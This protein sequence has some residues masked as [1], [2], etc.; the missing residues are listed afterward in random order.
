MQDDAKPAFHPQV[1][2]PSSEAHARDCEIS[3]QQMGVWL[4]GHLAESELY[5]LVYYRIF[6]EMLDERAARHAIDTIV[7]RHAALRCVFRIDQGRVLLKALDEAHAPW[8]ASRFES[9]DPVA[10]EAH[11]ASRADA[12]N[13]R[14]FDLA[15]GP[16][17]RV[18]YIALGA[19]RCALIL[20]VHHIC[21]DAWS[22]GV[23]E[24]EFKALYDAA[25]AGASVDLPDV[26][27]HY[28]AYCRSQHERVHD[29][30]FRE[31]VDYWRQRLSG[32]A[33][34]HGLPLDAPRPARRGHRG[35]LHSAGLGAALSR[36]CAELAAANGV[37]LFM[38]IHAAFATLIARHSNRS[39]V[40]IGIPFANR[41]DM[42]GDDV[43]RDHVIG[44]FADP[45]VLR[46]D[47]S[48]G[49]TFADLLDAV[50]TARI[51]AYEHSAV[52]FSL[53][54]TELD[55]ERD[56]R[57]TPLFQI[58]LNMAEEGGDEDAP[59]GF[60]LA[61]TDQAK[62]DLNLYVSNDGGEIGFHFTYNAEIFTEE[63]ICTWHRHL[64][65]LI[66][67]ASD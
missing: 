7:A 28:L 6:D 55:I 51:E 13:R 19:E 20:A 5:N 42:H 65:R 26:D 11:V 44:M 36:R 23:F 16:L 40:V 39:D 54:L 46:V 66:D 22:I 48:A 31:S 32:L 67:S 49:Y 62:Y 14:P 17:L 37:S 33:P 57:V 59:P 61:L 60:R 15:T 24:N 12:E 8:A 27:G 45:L 10:Q 50:R 30:D 43:D 64:V 41:F 56:D 47:C 29:A 4:H 53:L 2:K 34:L 35:G 38:A 1:D 63:T 9:M 18:E 58:M 3:F 52:P 21:F 25:V